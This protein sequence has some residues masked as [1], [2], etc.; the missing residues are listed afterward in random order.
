MHIHKAKKLRKGDKVNYWPEE[1]LS[2]VIT[3]RKITY[4]GEGLFCIVGDV[5][6]VIECSARHLV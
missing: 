3:I 2:A 6:T 4:H 5:G 1:G